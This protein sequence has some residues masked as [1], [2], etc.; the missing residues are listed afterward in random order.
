MT[1]SGF[2]T[3]ADETSMIS[4]VLSTGPLSVCLD[5]SKWATYTSGIVSSCSKNIDH[6][7]QVVGIDTTEQYW[8]VRNSW[9]TDWG[10][11]GYIYLE[12]GVDMCGITYDPTFVVPLKV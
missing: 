6:C 1:V 10:A 8:K 12:S 11:D 5:A 7:V 4:Y 2:K 3:I 9:G